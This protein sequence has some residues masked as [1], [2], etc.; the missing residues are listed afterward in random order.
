M[1]KLAAAVEAS[2]D[3]LMKEIAWVAPALAGGSFVVSPVRQIFSRI[4]RNC[5]AG[6]CLNERLCGKLRS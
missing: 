1:A 5:R 3:E 6:R 2:P 4:E